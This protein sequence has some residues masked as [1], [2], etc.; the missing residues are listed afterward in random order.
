MYLLRNQTVLR[1]EKEKF[2]PHKLLSVVTSKYKFVGERNVKVNI[3][4]VK[5][6]TLGKLL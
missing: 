4:G 5:M 1:E 2:Y 3:S 6:R